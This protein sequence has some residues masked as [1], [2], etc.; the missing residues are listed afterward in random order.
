MRMLKIW[1]IFLWNFYWGQTCRLTLVYFPAWKDKILIT[2]PLLKTLMSRC[3]PEAGHERN[4]QH[5]PCLQLPLWLS[6]CTINHISALRAL[7]LVHDVL[8]PQTNTLGLVWWDRLS[9]GTVLG[10]VAQWGILPSQSTHFSPRGSWQEPS[11]LL[12]LWG[13]WSSEPIF[14]AFC[15]VVFWFVLFFFFL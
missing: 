7:T 4:L 5:Q 15:F 1:L 3:L 12:V 14:S 6:L 2:K 9:E 11:A 13:S 10:T 8:W